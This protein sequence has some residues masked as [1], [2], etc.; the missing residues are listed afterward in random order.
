MWAQGSIPSSLP[1]H[2][3]SQ[4]NCL[5]SR[6]AFIPQLQ[7]TSRLYGV[8]SVSSLPWWRLRIGGMQGEPCGGA[9]FDMH[10]LREAKASRQSRLDRPSDIH[11]R[12][13]LLRIELANMEFV[14]PPHSYC[15]R[16]AW[17]WSVFS[18]NFE[19][20]KYIIERRTEVSD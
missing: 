7:N 1:A 5:C 8:A 16:R 12:S 17:P 9:S 19:V 10:A 3:A 15:L 20:G 11:R 18:V 2:H 6:A 13:V 14:R 4:R